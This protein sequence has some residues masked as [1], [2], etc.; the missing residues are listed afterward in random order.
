VSHVTPLNTFEIEPTASLRGSVLWLHG[1]GA[2]NHDFEDLVPELGTPHLRYVFPA[3]PKR[4]VTINGGMVMPAWYDILSFSDPPLR[5]DEPSVR[6]AALQ[7]TALIER[8][9]A[10]GVPANRIVLAGFSQG[11]AMALHVGA[12]YPEALG[13]IMVLSAYLLLPQALDAERHASNSATPLLFCHG[14]FDPVVPF[15]LGE[16]AFEQLKS[17]GY[18]AEFHAFAMPHSMCLPE[19]AVISAWL[20]RRF[21]ESP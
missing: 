18:S 21:D 20:H 12:R 8:E 1:L 16:A 19:V 3:A 17:A 2:S 9:I 13:G 15:Y 11:G 5:E 4:P 6:E 10:R 14:R 7:V